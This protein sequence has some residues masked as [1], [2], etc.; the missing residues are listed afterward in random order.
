MAPLD[1]LPLS[2]TPRCSGS[3]GRGWLVWDSFNGSAED[4][5]RRAVAQPWTRNS[6]KLVG[7]NGPAPK[8]RPT[9]SLV[10][11]LFQIWSARWVFPSGRTTPG[12]GALQEVFS[13][14]STGR[15]LSHQAIR[16]F[17]HVLISQI[18]CIKRWCRQPSLTQIRLCTAKSLH[19]ATDRCNR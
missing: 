7:V 14:R 15:F 11:F 9:T 19:I 3:L 16:N 13:L 12:S 1:R 18:K 4:L 5:G 2:L 10:K 6:P 17:C 8:K